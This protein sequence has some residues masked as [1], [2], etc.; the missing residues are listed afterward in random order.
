MS[1]NRLS[2]G[3][4]KLKKED[5]LSVVPAQYVKEE[6]GKFTIDPTPLNTE[7]FY[8]AVRI[9]NPGYPEIG[10][11][12]K[13][14]LQSYNLYITKGTTNGVESVSTK[15]GVNISITADGIQLSTEI[16]VGVS[17]FNVHGTKVW[18]GIAPT[19]RILYKG[20][21]SILQTEEMATLSRSITKQN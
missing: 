7:N 19:K 14:Y 12:G 2:L 3:Y 20:V 10:S 4:G 17:I 11:K 8:V 9:T 15:E 13:N 1:R 16:Q 6:N 21:F 5:K 18:E